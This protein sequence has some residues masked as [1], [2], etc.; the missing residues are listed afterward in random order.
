MTK[1]HANIQGNMLD[2]HFNNISDYVNLWPKEYPY[3]SLKP[4]R[5]AV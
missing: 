5:L 4:P 1:M 3:K 2:R